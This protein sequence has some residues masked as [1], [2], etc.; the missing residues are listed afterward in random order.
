MVQ[1]EEI[2]TIP[3]LFSSIYVYLGTEV[4]PMAFRH[5]WTSI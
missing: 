3:F 5:A 1:S 2:M 4:S